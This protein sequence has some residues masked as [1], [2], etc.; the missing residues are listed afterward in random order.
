M[1]FIPGAKPTAPPTQTGLMAGR[2]FTALVFVLVLIGAVAAVFASDDA[3]GRNTAASAF[4]AASAL[5][6][7]AA[8]A[9]YVRGDYIL[10]M[11]GCAWPLILAKA[12]EMQRAQRQRA[13]SFTFIVFL[14]VASIWIG[15]HI[16]VM[17]AQKGAGG[18]LTGLF[19]G[20]PWGQA[21][22]LVA[23]F[24]TLALTPQAYLA[25]TLKPLGA[26]EAE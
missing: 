1:S 17:A 24:F 2:V 20:E 13:F 18:T 23:V 10:R 11:F 22:V 9:M 15:A 14:S 21:A 5:Y 25:W 19:P 12:D 7:V 4:V 6:T 3:A 16:G 8:T 26:E